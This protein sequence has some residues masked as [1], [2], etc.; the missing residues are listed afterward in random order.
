[1]LTTCKQGRRIVSRTGCLNTACDHLDKS[2]IYCSA[3]CSRR[4]KSQKSKNASKGASRRASPLQGDHP[5]FRK[6]S[7]QHQS[8]INLLNWKPPTTSPESRPQLD[9]PALDKKWQAIWERQK[10]ETPTVDAINGD[11][12][13]VDFMMSIHSDG[14]TKYILPMFPYPSG[15]LHLG[16]VRVYTISDVLAR[17]HT[18]KG[19]R[20]LHPIAWDAFGL[21]AENAAIER[22]IDPA[23]W[24]YANIEKM[25]SQ[26]QSMNGKWDW[27]RVCIVKT[28]P[29]GFADNG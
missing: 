8:I 27:D 9:L 17:F 15:D 5:L 7:F 23:V 20:V 14:P 25:K 3:R 10:T 16:H 22:G 2:S 11:M 19:C 21:P 29:C 4:F 28:G 26:L 6:H 12:T 13:E 1:M 24:T 18:S